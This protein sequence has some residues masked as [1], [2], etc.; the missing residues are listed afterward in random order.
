MLYKKIRLPHEGDEGQ[1]STNA[2]RLKNSADHHHNHKKRAV[3][4]FLRRED[5]KNL[6]K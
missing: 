4:E 1:N 5:G 2:N 6:Q 3:T